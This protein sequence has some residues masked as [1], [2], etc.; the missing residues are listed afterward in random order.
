MSMND[1]PEVSVI[2]TTY[3][4][5]NLLKETLNSIL[6]QTY[7]NFE[8]IVVD[9]Y[10]NY[11]FMEFMRSFD[12]DKIRAF[13][14]QNNGIIAVNR[15]YGILKAKGK[16]LAFCDDDDLWIPDKLEKE[17][18]AIKEEHAD[19]VSS[20]SF[21]FYD[22]VINQC[23]KT[24]KK[25][26]SNINDFL[27]ENFI[28]TSSVMLRSGNLVYF[29]ES[30]TFLTVE[31]YNLWLVLYMNKYKFVFLDEPTIYYRITNNGNFAKQSLNKYL[32]RIIVLVN[33]KLQFQ[34]ISGL[35]VF[36]Y[37]IID[38]SK[39][40]VKFLFNRKVIWKRQKI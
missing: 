6:A 13:Q 24:N 2:V 15:N 28:I 8:L 37:S 5:K 20:N 11:N 30:R 7:K 21:L 14:N 32:K 18:L 31:D 1:N 25:I 35:R 38:V 23:Y 40:F 12:S 19:F 9:N 3:N 39:Y 26:A 16:F 4:R 29:D 33:V 22:N 36:F 27:K 10:S 17:L 34:E